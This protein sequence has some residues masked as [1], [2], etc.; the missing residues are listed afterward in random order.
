[1]A[2]TTEAVSVDT[3]TTK[4]EVTVEDLQKQVTEL[5]A[6][7]KA[8]EAKL[9]EAIAERQAAKAKAKEEADKAVT[10]AIAKGEHEKVIAQLTQEKEAWTTETERLVKIEQDYTALLEKQ[11]ETL[12]NKIPEASREKFKTASLDILETIVETFTSETVG[13]HTG[14]VV[15]GQQ[16]ADKPWNEMSYAEQAAWSQGKTSQQIAEK[17][18]GKKN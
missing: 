7:N 3:Q 1:M 16:L 9:K 13:T 18:S 12:L 15:N 17:I 11:R 6:A 2:D 4:T 8:S 10:E 5:A 14:K